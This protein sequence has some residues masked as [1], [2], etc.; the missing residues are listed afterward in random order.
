M[1]NYHHTRFGRKFE[2]GGTRRFLQ[3]LTIRSM[4]V[5]LLGLTL[6]GIVIAA[7]LDLLLKV[8]LA[9]IPLS[10]TLVF[11]LVRP[12]DRPFEEF[13]MN[14]VNFR[15]KPKASVFK[16]HRGDDLSSVLVDPLLNQQST[17]VTPVPSALA[18]PR[19][20]APAIGWGQVSL[21][22]VLIGFW[23]VTVTSLFLVALL[24]S[25]LMF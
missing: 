20:E 7:D 22:G 9:A 24:R 4:L 12:N 15:R 3:G 6:A 21:A 8:P 19:V 13:L 11:L 25:R 1:S 14:W 23:M 17:A 18:R 10:I 2:T 5:L 16:G